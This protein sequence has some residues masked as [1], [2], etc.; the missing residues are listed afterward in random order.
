M[1]KTRLFI[2]CA[3]AV[4]FLLPSVTF[5]QLP[6]ISAEQVTAWMTGKQKAVLIDVRLPQE[7]AEAHIPGALN[8]PA[9][10][11]HLEKNRL[12]KDKSTPIIF[13]CRGVG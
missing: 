12:P 11:I 7:Y 1:I 9:E 5:A 8:I 4:I 3:A 13:Y 10:R 6:V 2:L